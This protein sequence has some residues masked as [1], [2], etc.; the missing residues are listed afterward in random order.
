MRLG[1]GG[2]GAGAHGVPAFI[3]RGLRP[4]AGV[5]RFS[6]PSVLACATATW[7]SGE[8]LKEPRHSVRRRRGHQMRACFFVPDFDTPL[9]LPVFSWVCS[10]STPNFS[11]EKFQRPM[12]AFL[13]SFHHG[14]RRCFECTRAGYKVKVSEEVT[15]KRD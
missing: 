1:R 4:G 13:R 7:A 15:D 8:E 11:V 3:V 12:A 14:Q 2:A 6:G 9:P 10:E 5:G